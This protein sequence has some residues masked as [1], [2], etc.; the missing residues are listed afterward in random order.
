MTNTDE[1]SSPSS[2]NRSPT[3]PELWTVETELWTGLGRQRHFYVAPGT[4]TVVSTLSVSPR[5]L[6]GRFSA[7]MMTCSIDFWA[8]VS[9]IFLRAN[10]TETGGNGWWWSRNED[11]AM[12]FASPFILNTN[13]SCANC[14]GRKAGA[15]PCEAARSERAKEA[16][17]S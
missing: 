14:W 11:G 13:Q 2:R 5:G 16:K 6:H 1:I 8:R 3:S 17:R 4:G 12:L 9:E 15:N 7:L 10:H